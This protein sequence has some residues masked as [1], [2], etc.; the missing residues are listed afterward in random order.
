[1]RNSIYLLLQVPAGRLSPFVP[2]PLSLGYWP[3]LEDWF[4]KI[5]AYPN[6][7]SFSQY[8]GPLD[9]SP[10]PIMKYWNDPTHFN[11]NA[12]RLMLKAFLETSSSASPSN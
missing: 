1:M 8:N 3:L 11:V 12:G 9:E 7:I 2:C 4:V 6:V 10:A 5:S